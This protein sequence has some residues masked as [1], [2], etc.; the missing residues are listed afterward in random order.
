MTTP[1]PIE[2]ATRNQQ[3]AADPRHSVW[4]SA[5]AGTGKTKVLTDRVLSLLLQGT[6]PNRLLCLTFTKAA[7]SEMMTRV[8]QRL[9][10]WATCADDA[11]ARDL[12]QLTGQP[13]QPRDL[14]RAR[15]LFAT[16]LD[17]PGGLKIQTIHAFCQALLSRFPLEAEI[18]PHFSVI[19][20]A[21]AE[22]LRREAREA[23]LA[24][25]R[26]R[27]LGG[28]IDPD[29]AA[30]LATITDH[31]QETE[32]AELLAAL[33]DERGR[34]GRMIALHDDVEGL[35]AAI[36]DRLGLP[37][38]T[39]AENARAELATLGRAREADLRAAVAALARGSANDQQSG[40][41]IQDFLDHAAR[42]DAYA[43]YR[44]VFFTTK[45]ELRKNLAS[46]P[47]LKAAPDLGTI[48]EAEAAR[49]I[50]FEARLK[51]ATMLEATASLLRL[52]DA[53]LEAYAAAK[54][55]RVALD[56]DDLILK[57]R[58]LLRSDGGCSWVLY[59]LDGGL[60]HI[61]IDEAQDTNPE[62][63]EVVQ[64]LAEEF[65]AG[66]GVA[67]R[68]RT[69]FAVGDAKQSIFSFQRAD[70]AAFERMREHFKLRV[71]EAKQQW[72]EIPLDVSFRSTASVL[73]AVDAV[74]NQPV[75]RDGV[76][77]GPLKHELSRDGHAGL[78]ELWPLA[79]LPE[80]APVDDW[81]PPLPQAAAEAPVV[82]A[83][84]LVA[85]HIHALCGSGAALESRGRPIGAGD[86]LVLVRRR[87]AFV[88]AL[89]RALKLLEIPV[90]GVDRMVLTDQLA[91]MDLVALG[92]FLLLPE[93]DLT[94]ACV[95]KSPL[96]GFDEAALFRLAHERRDT[97]WAA[98]GDAAGT[99]AACAAAHVY[100]A[101][102]LAQADFMPPFELFSRVLARDR[103]REK[104][105]A[106]LGEEANDPID[107]FL[108]QCLVYERGHVASL[109]G[110]LHWLERGGLEVKR[111]S[112]VGPRDEVRIMTVHGAKGLQAPIVIL[113][114]TMQKPG[115]AER[116][117]WPDAPTRGL[118]WGPLW[119]PRTR[120]DDA[121]A[122][123]LRRAAAAARDREYRRLLYVAL[124]RA[125]DRLY[126]VGW[127][128]RRDAP[129]DC[130]YRLVEAG[131][132][133]LGDTGAERVAFDFGSLGFADWR[134]EGWRL[135]RAQSAAPA[136]GA[137]PSTAI[138]P[139]REFPAWVRAAP[140][141]EPAPGRPL[142]P[143][144]PDEAPPVRSPLGDDDGVR[145]RRGRLIHRLLQTLPELPAARRDAAGRRFLGQ[146]H[147]GLADGEAEALLAETLRVMD[148][149]RF[150]PL[151][152][153]ASQAE[154]PLVGRLGATVVS[155]Q[156]DRLAVAADRVLIL[157]Y[158]TNR[159]PP[160]RV[161]DVAPA[162]LRQLATYR[163]LVRRIYPDHT[164]EAALL[165]TDGP[166]LMTVP[167]A[168]LEAIIPFA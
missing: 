135:S 66:D 113:A 22:E 35:I 65:F 51:R 127:R 30:A 68:P 28:A 106:R 23:V 4:V 121:Q 8:V 153:P 25:T 119:V 62:Q 166:A 115:K 111:D 37:P 110:F 146:A 75:A 81:Q 105:L 20:E 86:I 159:P 95:L 147:H 152:G 45:D 19:D 54:R 124:T 93:D 145:F 126:V 14:V 77:D 38:G 63:W 108:G 136:P 129:P 18:A 50:E 84:R 163:A 109:E 90:A 11:L 13:P 138:A 69:I 92:R 15:Q 141:Q 132:A 100:L 155:G 83:A 122:G 17:T 103:G 43:T 107:E 7:A 16:V 71:N 99:D 39:T 151:F 44:N 168:L 34:I 133:A 59:K 29:L 148:E 143:S 137:L 112:D 55:N 149:P 40:A 67:E 130:W 101:G 42:Q 118:P 164:V 156:I 142:A 131:L 64:A 48:L 162:Y 6:P 47:C 87:T 46:K 91:V 94:L 80:R 158:K 52:G 161:E 27:D 88:E 128:A 24:R 33:T 140:A 78:V 82:R 116:L 3:L 56:Y 139:A 31:V 53:L 89:V 70:P 150:A 167:A 26:A 117:L 2:R 74:F 57:T 60:D 49:L 157:D 58:D 160:A 144:R 165:W 120:H 134:G 72:R 85:R 32:F 102:L 21:T 96:L 1:S 10:A 9:G 104:L 12:R 114:D 79:P 73:H 76:I 41:A 61:L 97:L 98:L 125:E 154:V 123:A 36:A 5:S